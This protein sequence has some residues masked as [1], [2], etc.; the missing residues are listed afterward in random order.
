MTRFFSIR[1][2]DRLVHK[3]PARGFTIAQLMAVTACTAVAACVLLPALATSAQ[4]NANVICLSHLK[5]LSAGVLTYAQAYESRLPGPL[6]PALYQNLRESYPDSEPNAEFWRGRILT[7]KLREVMT[8]ATADRL[9]VCPAMN[10][11]VP[12]SSFRAFLQATGRHVPPTHYTVNNWMEGIGIVGTAPP[13]YFGFSYGSPSSGYDTP[14]LTLGEIPRL[15]EEWMIADAWFRSKESIFE[16]FTQEGT[17]QS[18]WSGQALPFVAPHMR[19]TSTGY[20]F[21]GAANPSR[22]CQAKLD[23]WTNAAFFD[24]H[25]ASVPPRRAHF[26]GTQLFYGFPGTVNPANP[27][28]PG[29]NI[30]WE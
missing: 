26:N 25:A 30:R 21:T 24:G 17:Y 16:R 5:D 13:A 22:I 10:R 14:P 20:Q 28:P 3:A 7:W 11:I 23:G 6:H 9:A 15:S 12:D 1:R 18:Q 19:R 8:E 4:R 2:P 27:L 29:L